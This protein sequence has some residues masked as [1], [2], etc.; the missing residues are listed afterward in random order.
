MGF[1]DDELQEVSQ[2]CHNVVDGS[3]LVSCVPSMV[4]VEITKTPFKQLV[5]CIQFQKDYPASPL[6]V[7]LKSKTLSAKLL[8]GL[9]EVCEKECKRLLNKAQILPILK[10]IRNFIEENPLICCYEEI[11]ILKKLLGDKDE[12]K[13]KQKNS[14]I[15]LTLHQDLY[16]FKTKLEVP[17][18]YPTNC[19]I[20]SD[21]DTNFPPLFNRYLVGQGR[22]LAR[23]CVEPPLRKQQ[24]PFTPSPS[25][26]TVVSFLIKS[27]KAF[28]Q[29]SCQHCKVKCLP[30]D[31]KEI[32]IDENADF[33]AERLYCGHLFHLK[34]LVTYMKTPP[35]H[36]GKKCPSCGQRV[37]HDKWGL[38][39]RLAEARWAH[40][41]ARMRELAEVE[42]F[43]N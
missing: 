34:C 1:I 14:S 37:Y 35:F 6:F 42:D 30:T 22:E 20:Y 25:L 32:V 9:T 39:D 29:E 19:V 40:Q 8:D 23:K 36:G 17:D 41:E 12:F 7:E 26:N 21:V 5:V 3:R 28:P 33:H 2:L 4:R 38:S 43:F 24:N 10:F 27:V 18:N 15:N 16:H 31:P 13:L 11:S